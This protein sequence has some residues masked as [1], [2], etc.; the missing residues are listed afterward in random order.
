[1]AS[2]GPPPPSVVERSG[3]ACMYQTPTHGRCCTPAARGHVGL[4]PQALPAGP[5]A[6]PCVPCM[7]H[8]LTVTGIRCINADSPPAPQ[9]MLCMQAV[10][11]GTAPSHACISMNVHSAGCR[12]IALHGPSPPARPPPERMHAL[13]SAHP[14]SAPHR[15]AAAAAC[16]TVITGLLW[17]AVQ[18]M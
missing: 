1:M 18:L 5:Q 11:L 6:L 8:S 3:W 10:R 14:H 16:R 13:M 7:P 17:Q 2:S 15:G 4:D 9:C 12:L